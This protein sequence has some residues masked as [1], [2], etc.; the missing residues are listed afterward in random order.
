MVGPNHG[1]FSALLWLL[2]LNDSIPMPIDYFL[3]DR[4]TPEKH[5]R[6]EMQ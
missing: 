4:E 6:K 2:Y 1:T 5:L 3:A